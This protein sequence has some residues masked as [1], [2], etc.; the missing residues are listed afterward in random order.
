VPKARRRRQRGEASADST[1]EA[2]PA[3]AIPI[4]VP[5]KRSLCTVCF[6]VLPADSEATTCS[7]ACAKMVSM[8]NELSSEAPK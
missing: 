5:A 8:P 1:V 7:P 4:S 6:E 3:A 2:E